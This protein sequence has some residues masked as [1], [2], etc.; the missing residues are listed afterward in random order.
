M[1]N[2]AKAP[3]G[4][5]YSGKWFVILLF[6]GFI[7]FSLVMTLGTFWIGKTFGKPRSQAPLH[8]SPRT[9]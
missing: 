8:A 2:V 4:K 7:V 6:A 9:P 5:V 3:D 1:E